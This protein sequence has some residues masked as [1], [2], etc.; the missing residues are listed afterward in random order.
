[1]SCTWCRCTVRNSLSIDLIFCA[2]LSLATSFIDSS[3]KYIFNFSYN[4]T[5][6]KKRQMDA[7]PFI[8]RRLIF[9]SNTMESCVSLK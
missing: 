7:S 9:F 4:D 5:Q 6:L 8:I 2:E 1:M 3:R